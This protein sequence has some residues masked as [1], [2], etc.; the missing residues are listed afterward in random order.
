MAVYLLIHGSFQGGWTW[1][2][3][4]RLLRRAGHDVYAPTLEGCAE[5]AAGLRPGISVTTCAGELAGFLFNEDLESV[6][7]V[8]TS[9]GGL[10]VEKLAVLAPGRIGRLVFV[11]A[12]VPQPGQQVRDIVERPAGAPPY[13]STSLARGPGREQLASGLFA[14]FEPA[15]KHWALERATL[16]PLGLSEP[17]PGELDAF[18]ERAWEATLI[19]CRQSR[20]PPLSHQRA[21]AER[22]GARW[23]EIESGH[24]PMLTDPEETARLLQV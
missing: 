5:R 18:W 16:H 12:L 11:D 20:N 8:G 22:L 19:R 7:L 2:P 4:A 1:K 21:T 24:Y 15:L 23:L 9:S 17:E 3:T 13:E 14:D 6:V 10:V